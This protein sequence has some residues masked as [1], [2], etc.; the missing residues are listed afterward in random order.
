VA[1]GRDRG[2]AGAAAVRLDAGG[3]SRDD[4]RALILDELREL[5]RG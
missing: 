2:A 4:L 1:A 3:L 5:V